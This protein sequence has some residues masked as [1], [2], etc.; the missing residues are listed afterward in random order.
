VKT[1]SIAGAAALAGALLATSAATAA[2]AATAATAAPKLTSDQIVPNKSI[3]GLTLNGSVASARKVFGAAA[4]NTGGCDYAG[5]NNTW[6]LSVMFATTAKKAKPK[7]V[8][9]T[10]F[11]PTPTSSAPALQTAQGI[12]IGSTAAAVKKAYPHLLGSPTTGLYTS[13]KALATA[14]EIE[15]GHVSEISM[16]SVHLG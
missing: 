2:P 11:E 13:T 3:G 6:T 16:H 4:C 7:I 8:S 10:F 12:G 9:I 5:P 1:S 14:Y 15:K